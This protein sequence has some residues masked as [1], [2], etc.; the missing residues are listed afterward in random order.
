MDGERRRGQSNNPLLR[1]WNAQR[2]RFPDRPLVAHLVNPECVINFD[3]PSPPEND[4]N[5]WGL[6]IGGRF[7]RAIKGEEE[8]YCSGVEGMKS[9]E[10]ILA[11]EQAALSGRTVKIK[12]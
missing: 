11:A 4:D 8:P 3:V 6:D 1:K 7:C 5:G 9:L 10:V 12:H 2:L